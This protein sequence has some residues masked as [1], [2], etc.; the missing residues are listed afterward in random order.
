MTPQVCLTARVVREGVEDTE[1]RRAKTDR[2]PGDGGRL[3]VEVVD[4]GVGI[5]AEAQAGVGLLTAMGYDYVPGNLAGA[6]ALR[7][8][9]PDRG[10][11]TWW[12]P[13]Q[14]TRL[15]SCGRTSIWRCSKWG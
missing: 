13:S 6:F 12:G 7:D 4:D 11:W 14:S 15:T 1:L 5:P 10:C 2:E 3:L 8:A 9:G